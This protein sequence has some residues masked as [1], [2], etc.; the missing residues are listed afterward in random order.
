VA[1]CSSGS[2]ENIPGNGQFG[3]TEQAWTGDS[4]PTVVVLGDSITHMARDA[5]H[6]A[7]AGYQVRIAAGVGEG[8]S[9]GPI[10]DGEGVH[11]MA[12]IAEAYAELDP[13]IA[14]LA[15][16]TNDALQPGLTLD[17]ALASMRSIVEDFAG[18]C[19]VGVEVNTAATAAGFDPDEARAINDALVQLADETVD[20]EQVA[21]SGFEPDGIH[22]RPDAT[23]AYAQLVADAVGRCAAR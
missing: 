6:Q 2:A 10:S 18:A 21:A 5:L 8:W 1:A 13:D 16:G 20:I 12:D 11:V 3:A 19:V 23:P 4:G 14:V 17:A 15:L 22:P 7:L 9:G